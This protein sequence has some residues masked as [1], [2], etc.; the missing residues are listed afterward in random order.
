MHKPNRLKVRITKTVEF[1]EP[2]SLDE[3]EPDLV[4][5][6]ADPNEVIPRKITSL[7]QILGVDET[8]AQRMYFD[9]VGE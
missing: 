8:T 4:D 6:L 9:H 1:F 7:A 5:D 2:I 3:V